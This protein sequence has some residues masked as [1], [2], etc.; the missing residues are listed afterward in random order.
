MFAATFL[1]N[2]SIVSTCFS[3]RTFSLLLSLFLA[4]FRFTPLTWRT[5]SFLMG[6]ETR[7]TLLANLLPLVHLPKHLH[8]RTD[9]QKEIRVEVDGKVI[10]LPAVEG[11][12]ILNILR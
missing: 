6:D 1:Y 4:F 10:N 12:I 5:Q 11:I 9:L 8:K 3:M 2:A 7:S